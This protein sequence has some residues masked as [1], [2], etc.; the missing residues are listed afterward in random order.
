[1]LGSGLLSPQCTPPS[2]PIRTSIGRNIRRRTHHVR[3]LLRHESEPDHELKLTT[4]ARKIERDHVALPV[5]RKRRCHDLVPA[6]SITT[7]P[8]AVDFPARGRDVALGRTHATPLRPES[9]SR[10][11]S[12]NCQRV[13]S[14]PSRFQ[15]RYMI[16][17]RWSRGSTRNTHLAFHLT[18]RSAFRCR[19]AYRPTGSVSRHRPP[20]ACAIVMR[21]SV[22]KPLSNPTPSDCSRHSVLECNNSVLCATTRRLAT[23]IPFGIIA[24]GKHRRLVARPAPWFLEHDDF[25][26]AAWPAD[27]R[28]AL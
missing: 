10:R 27:L 13:D 19:F 7:G 28:L 26:V 2:G 5:G 16:S 8:D 17:I 12:S 14:G 15:S 11:S 21:A 20:R 22:P 3:H 23:S 1:M 6:N 9:V 24:V 4:L 25:V 18:T